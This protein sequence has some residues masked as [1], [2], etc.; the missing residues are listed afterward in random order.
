[1]LRFPASTLLQ[2]EMDA[3]KENISVRRKLIAERREGLRQEFE[4]HTQLKKDIEVR[5]RADVDS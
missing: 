5:L 1:M 2:R 3:L 4:T